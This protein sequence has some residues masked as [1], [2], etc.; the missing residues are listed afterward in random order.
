MYTLIKIMGLWIEQILIFITNFDLLIIYVLVL[1][2]AIF[3]TS[4]I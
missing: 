1:I 2:K 4:K 3:Y